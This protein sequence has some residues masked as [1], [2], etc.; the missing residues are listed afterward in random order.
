MD[1][2]ALPIKA[3]F[4]K[5]LEFQINTQ[6]DGQLGGIVEVEHGYHLKFDIP[7]TFGGPGKAFCPDELFLASI[8]GCLMNTFLHFQGQIEF[9]MVAFS[10]HVR[11]VMNFERG[12]Y[13]ITKI[14]VEGTLTIEEGDEELGEEC[15]RLAKDYCH[16]SRSLA[17]CIPI[18]YHIGIES[19]PK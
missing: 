4:P 12:K 14:N 11:A 9:E 1:W 2:S 17:P 3:K 16:I 15:L 13:W 5:H 6:W 8:A 19:A 10:V 18:E 7:L